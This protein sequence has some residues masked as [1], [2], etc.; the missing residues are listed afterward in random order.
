MLLYHY[1]NEQYGIEALQNSCL[2]IGRLNN[3]NDPFEY[4]HIDINNTSMRDIIRYRRKR[5]NR[6]Y[7]LICFSKNFSNPV[8][9]AHY[10]DSHKGLCLGFEI[11]EDLVVKIDYIQER[12]SASEFS[13]SLDLKEESYLE[14]MLSRKYNHWS[15]EQEYRIIIKLSEKKNDHSFIFEKFSENIN[16]KILNYKVA[17]YGGFKL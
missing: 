13:K 7:G 1:L 16:Y 8:Q 17:A 2:K 15:Y 9:W 3:L 5:A 14:Y 6:N 12:T 11:P 10:A 4:Y